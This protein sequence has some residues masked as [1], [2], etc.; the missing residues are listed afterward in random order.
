VQPNASLRA[1]ATG[2][3][4]NPL[5]EDGKADIYAAGYYTFPTV[6]AGMLLPDPKNTRYAYAVGARLKYVN[7]V[8]THYIADA[9]AIAGQSRPQLAP[10]MGGRESLNKRGVALDLGVLVRPKR[11]NRDFTAALVVA[12]AVRTP[13]TFDGTDRDGNPKRFN[14]L[15]TTVTAGVGYQKGGFAAAAD[16]AD[17]T[18]STGRPQLRAGAEYKLNFQIAVRGGYNSA[19]GFT[20]GIG[21][22]G[23]DVAFAKN[24]PLEVVKTIDF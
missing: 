23:L 8:Y 12:N 7:A 21:F 1:W 4:T 11:G 5:P 20:A 3:N 24:Q 18:G 16:L 6:A 22:F 9:P 15:A 17:I 10:E 14:I 2:P 19:T 13:F